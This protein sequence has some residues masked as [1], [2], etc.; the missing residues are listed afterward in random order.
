MEVTMEN[1]ET[2]FG[3]VPLDEGQQKMV[4]HITKHFTT[5]AREVL[6]SVPRCADRSAVLRQLREAKMI[7]VDAIA[8]GGLI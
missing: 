8:K 5:L 2:V 3:S 7:A 1:H 4:E 6:L